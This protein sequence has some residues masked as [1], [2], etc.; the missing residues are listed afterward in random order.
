MAIL[1]SGV[2]LAQI[3][4]LVCQPI[5]TRLYTAED[6]GVLAIVTSIVT[7]CIPLVT[8]QYQMGIVTAKDDEE[9]NIVC[10]LTFYLL[11][12]MVLIMSIVLITI[13]NLN[14]RIF[15]QVGNWIYVSLPLLL[16]SGFAKIADSYNNRFEQYK[17]MS[18]IALIRSIT[19]NFLKIFLGLF[20]VGFLG[21]IISQFVATIFGIRRQS[22]YIIS[23]KSEILSSTYQEMKHVAIKY[24]VQP[25][26]SMPG[27]FV[28][29]CSFSILP[30]FITSLYSIEDAGYF[31]LS[32]TILAIPL[33]L[34]SSNVGKVF[35]RKA[36][37]EKEKKGDFY[38]TFKSTV[39]LLI[40][41]AIVGFSILWLIAEPL[42]SLVFGPEWLKSGTF[43]KI[44][45]PLFAIRFVVTGLMHGFII[46]GRQKFKLFLQLFFIIIALTIY[47]ISQQQ[48]LP[49]EIFLELTNK[50]YFT[51]YLILLIVLYFTSK[52][53]NEERGI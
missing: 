25:L 1:S 11:C 48:E 2:I 50:G 36:T 8:L 19:S 31:F 7:M 27:L 13:D 43:V 15:E 21:L 3:I 44:L 49:I 16:F 47:F 39:I 24:R 35:F 5:I 4:A 53:N 37:L 23:K 22:N 20:K 28:S 32:M 34:V 38:N 26:F 42:F 51:L 40:F 18:S 41:I 14:P 46:S 29:V 52:N 30:I 33:S 17:L 9:A 45:I 6:F 10:A 12:F